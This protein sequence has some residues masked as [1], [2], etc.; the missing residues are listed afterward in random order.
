VQPFN[1][2][3]LATA[4]S[5]SDQRKLKIDGLL[6]HFRTGLVR[7][8]ITFFFSNKG[9]HF[10]SPPMFSVDRRAV[11]AAAALIFAATASLGAATDENAETAGAANADAAF[12]KTLGQLID[13]PGGPPGAIAVVQRDHQPVKVFRKGVADQETGARIL[14]PDRFRVGS[15][16]KAFNGAVALQLV[17]QGKLSLSDAIGQRLP[18][19]PAAW[20]NVTLGQ[21][22]NHTSGLPNFTKDPGWQRAAQEGEYLSPMDLIGLVSAQPLAFP[23][24]SSYAYSNTDNI[25]VGLFAEMA[26]GLSYDLLLYQLVFDRL[27]LRHTVMSLG[28]SMQEPFVH[29]YDNNA[30][31]ERDDISEALNMSE[32]WAAGA[33]ISSLFDLNRFIRSYAGGKLFGGATRAA[34]TD[35]VPGGESEPKGP[36]ENSAGMALFKYDTRCGTVYGHTGNF[37]GYTTIAVSSPDGRRSF[38]MLVS[39]QLDKAAGVPATF[40]FWRRTAE[41]GVCA[42]LAR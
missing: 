9:V 32:V 23:P 34:Q 28:F 39:T 14:V 35:F 31:G 30:T 27:H 25:V 37:P 26:T 5:D 20:H 2:F 12:D 13:Q 15:V 17:A 7:S 18:T 33:Q 38:V 24:G 6:N 36:G 1:R 40:R 29:G 21:L 22:L 4:S 16:G 11:A 19:L 42:A 10:S 3:P 8:F 41:D